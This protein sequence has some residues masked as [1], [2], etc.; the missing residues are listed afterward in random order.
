[1]KHLCEVTY[2]F[3]RSEVDQRFFVHC[4]A[5]PCVGRLWQLARAALASLRVPE[6][7]S[8]CSLKSLLFASWK[9]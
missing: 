1:M 9:E 4:Q 8:C 7:K 5:V 6:Q 2:L 3:P